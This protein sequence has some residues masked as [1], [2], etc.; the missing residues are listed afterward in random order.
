MTRYASSADF[1][2]RVLSRVTADYSGGRPA[3][4][5]NSEEQ[6]GAEQDLPKLHSARNNLGPMKRQTFADFAVGGPRCF[7]SSLH[8]LALWHAFR[9]FK[10][11]RWGWASGAAATVVGLGILA[12]FPALFNYLTPSGRL[13]VTGRVV[14]VTPNV[15][16]QII[17]IPVTPNVLV[18]PATCCFKLIPLHSNTRFRNW[19]PP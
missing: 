3:S 17:D 2:A 9:T 12:T 7:S 11:V 13:T 6:S 18:K 4:Q 19:K 16:G 1:A 8:V 10:P 15:S 5:Q 14:E